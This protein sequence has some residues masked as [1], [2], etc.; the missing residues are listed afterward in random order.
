MSGAHQYDGTLD[1]LS[2]QLCAGM[3]HACCQWGNVA[4]RGTSL[5]LEEERTHA[6]WSA[7]TQDLHFWPLQQFHLLVWLHD[8]QCMVLVG[9]RADLHQLSCYRTADNL[10][11]IALLLLLVCLPTCTYCPVL[12]STSSVTLKARASTRVQCWHLPW[13]SSGWTFSI[14]ELDSGESYC[15]QLGVVCAETSKGLVK[16]PCTLSQ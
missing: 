4:G 3:T 7:E 16:V 14:L 1:L 10:A 9:N 11:P 5:W 8:F 12:I 6:F 15:L 13:G 2:Q